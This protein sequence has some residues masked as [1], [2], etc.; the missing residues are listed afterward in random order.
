MILMQVVARPHP[1]RYF[2]S[3]NFI[4]PLLSCLQHFHSTFFHLTN[5]DSR[6]FSKQWSTAIKKV[7]AVIKFT[8]L[9][10]Y[11]QKLNQWAYGISE[12]EGYYTEK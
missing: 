2:R 9:L 1:E 5:I 11:Y 7:S 8:I 3:Q 12:D 10:G 4:T 6:H